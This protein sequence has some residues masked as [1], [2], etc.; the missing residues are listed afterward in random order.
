[1]AL[2]GE[3]YT[4]AGAVLGYCRVSGEDQNLAEQRAALR[5]AGCTRLFEEKASGGR[6]DRPQLQRLLDPLRAGDLVVVWKLDRLSRSLKDLLHIME[7]IGEAGAGFRSISEQI[8]TRTPAGRM[9]MQ[10]VVPSKNSNAP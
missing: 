6:W 2:I 4:V 7:K 10:V 3:L 1:M 5:N 8:D 9:M